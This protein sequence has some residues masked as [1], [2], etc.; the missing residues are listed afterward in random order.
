MEDIVKSI[1][2]KEQDQY[3]SNLCSLTPREMDIC[4]MIKAGQSSKEIADSLN[5]SPQTVHK[6]RESIRRTLQ[7]VNKEITLS[8]YLR[9]K[10]R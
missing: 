8:A 6:H 3:E 7:I 10:G 5:I 2:G 4:D 9:S 1:V